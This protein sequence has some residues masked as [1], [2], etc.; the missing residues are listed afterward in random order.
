M[1]SFEY[2]GKDNY[3]DSIMN[4]VL[5]KA[6]VTVAVIKGMFVMEYSGKSMKYTEFFNILV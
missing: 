5:M 6:M 3:N 4:T 1:V 2:V